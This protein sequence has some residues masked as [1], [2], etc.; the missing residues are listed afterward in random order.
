ME[1]PNTMNTIKLFLALCLSASCG[2]AW[3]QTNTPAQNKTQQD[4]YID[5]KGSYFDGVANQLVYTDHVI[6]TDHVKAWLNCERLTVD[7]PRNGGHPTNIVAETNV[8]IDFIDG[9]QTNH[10][11]CE[12]A[13]YAYHLSD[14]ITNI[15]NAITNVAFASTNV[16]YAT[17]NETVTFT[18]G[19][20]TLESSESVG[21]GEKLIYD[22]PK[23][24]FS[25]ITSSH[26]KLKGNG[27]NAPAFNLF[28]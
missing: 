1:T 11:I 2:I 18:G 17:T 28:K 6:V 22:V 5:S 21:T 7:V 4:I 25:G 27:T 14:P 19:P 3:A 10:L 23:K 24:T 15:V 8:V 20:P 13:V 26:L 16:S 9:G 12:K